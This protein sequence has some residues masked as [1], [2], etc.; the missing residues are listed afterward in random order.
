MQTELLKSFSKEHLEDL[1]EL[2]RQMAPER[3]L[4]SESKVKG[5]LESDSDIVVI[6]DNGRIVAM[7]TIGYFTTISGLY[8]EIT[9]VVV[10]QAHRGKGLGK[11]MTSAA[12]EQA[13]KRGVTKLH[14]ES[15]PERIIANVMYE[16]AG[17]KKLN[18]NFYRLT[19]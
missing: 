19:L 17:F 3:T 2:Y 14:L 6:R 1:L 9:H 12:I 15:D 4:P 5:L 16:K 8:G 10:D 13:K 11:A 18:K 7:T